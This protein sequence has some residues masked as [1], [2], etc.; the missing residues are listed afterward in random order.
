MTTSPQPAIIDAA[1]VLL[2]R[3]PGSSEVYLVRRALNLRF[4]GGFVAFP[5]GKVGAEDAALANG[6]GLDRIQVAA[7]RELFEE[8]G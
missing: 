5:G 6:A 7:I 3:G 2:S 8:T 4:F 1:S